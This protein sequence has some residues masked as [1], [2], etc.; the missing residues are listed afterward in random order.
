M[1]T[2]RSTTAT[3]VAVALITSGCAGRKPAPVDAAQVGDHNMSCEVIA[4][5]NRTNAARR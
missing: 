1:N 2:I 4:S 5:E 3:L